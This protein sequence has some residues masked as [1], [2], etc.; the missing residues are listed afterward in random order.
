MEFRIVGWLEYVSITSLNLL[1]IDAKIDSGAQTSALHAENIE[2]ITQ[3][4]EKFIR[5]NYPSQ[6]GDKYQVT[7]PFLGERQITSST[8]HLSVRP[9]IRVRIQMGSEEFETE[10]TLI[11]RQSMKYR[12]LIGRNT[13]QNRFLIDTAK[14]YLLT[15]H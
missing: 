13:L 15:G 3:N 7:A 1:M 4:K 12:A 9:V 10:M 11:N 8:G 6:D 5:F 2:L 14:T